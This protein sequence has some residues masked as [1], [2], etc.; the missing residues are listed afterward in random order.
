MNSGCLIFPI[1]QT[2]FYNLDWSLNKELIQETKVW[3]ELWAKSGARPNF[4][5]ENRVE[6]ISDF[7]WLSSW[8]QNYFFNKVSDFLLGFFL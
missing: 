6:Y 8:T 4:V 5:V 1:A 3:F 2:C 7:N